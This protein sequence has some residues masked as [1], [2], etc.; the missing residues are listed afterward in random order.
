MAHLG[1]TGRAYGRSMCLFNG[2][3]VIKRI[4]EAERKPFGL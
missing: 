4:S 2:V 3:T 1:Y